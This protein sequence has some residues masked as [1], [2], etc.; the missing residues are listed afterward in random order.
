M[1]EIRDERNGQV[2]G[3]VKDSKCVVN[4]RIRN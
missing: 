2:E 3:A 1:G 4:I